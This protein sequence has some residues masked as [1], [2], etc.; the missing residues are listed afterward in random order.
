MI[1]ITDV[2]DVTFYG[3]VL[4]QQTG[5]FDFA[6]Y[7]GNYNWNATTKKF[8]K[9][10]GSDITVS[11][12]SLSTELTLNCHYFT[13]YEKG[14]FDPDASRSYYRVKLGSVGMFMINYHFGKKKL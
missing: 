10:V 4:D 6:K 3:Y 1:S 11:F 2:L 12:P 8:D 5:R 14:S 13:P 9:S 7:A